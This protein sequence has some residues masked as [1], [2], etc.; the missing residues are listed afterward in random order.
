MDNTTTTHSFNTN[1]LPDDVL[2]YTDDK[3]YN[4]MKEVLGLW[5]ADL[6]NIQATNNVFIKC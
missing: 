6:S 1:Q 2:S 5:A 4:F 3:F